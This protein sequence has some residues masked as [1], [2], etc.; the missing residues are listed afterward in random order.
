MTLKP[1]GLSEHLPSHSFCVSETQTQ[2]SRI[3]WLEHH[4]DAIKCQ[5][6]LCPAHVIVGRSQFLTGPGTKGLSSSLA[7]TWRSLSSSPCEPLHRAAHHVAAGFIRASKSR[8]E[9][10]GVTIYYNLPSDDIHYSYHILLI[11]GESPCPAHTRGGV[12]PCARVP[13]SG[14]PWGCFGSCLPHPLIHSA[15]I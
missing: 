11:R 7:V 1:G 5:P 15:N 9:K 10:M 6:G 14:D 12:C 2:F 13:G 3:C 8:R 4:K